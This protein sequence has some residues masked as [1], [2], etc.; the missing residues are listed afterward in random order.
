MSAKNVTD[1]PSR[2][3]GLMV[4]LGGSDGKGWDVETWETPE[5]PAQL[6]AR[7][8]CRGDAVLFCAAPELIDA[9]REITEHAEEQY[10]HFESERGQRDI[11]KARA[12]L[13]R[14]AGGA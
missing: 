3:A 2:T 13:A 5:R 10:P 14:I 11:A 4:V 8:N 12:L 1:G 7:F 9:L 6:V